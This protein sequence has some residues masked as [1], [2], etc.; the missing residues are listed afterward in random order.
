M[1]ARSYL[2]LEEASDDHEAKTQTG[3]ALYADRGGSSP[4][5]GATSG[6]SGS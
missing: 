1:S 6:D 2:L 4:G 5:S 3:L